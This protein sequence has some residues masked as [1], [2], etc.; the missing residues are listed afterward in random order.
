MTLYVGSS[1]WAYKEWKPI[2]YPANAQKSWAGVGYLGHRNSTHFSRA[3][4]GW[5]VGTIR[6]VAWGCICFRS[7]AYS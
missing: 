2:F 5:G 6:G 7:Q 1:G 4:L 3:I